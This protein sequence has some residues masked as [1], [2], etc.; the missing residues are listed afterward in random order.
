MLTIFTCART[1][2]MHTGLLLQRSTIQLKILIVR[3]ADMFVGPPNIKIRPGTYVLYNSCMYVSN[4][5]AMFFMTQSITHD[6]HIT[7][8][9]TEKI[10]TYLPRSTLIR[11]QACTYRGQIESPKTS[12]ID[13]SFNGLH[14][15]INAIFLCKWDFRVT[16]TAY[17]FKWK[18]G[19]NISKM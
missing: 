9:D 15:A 10:L 3:M 19:S 17:L 14:L 16:F 4:D 6:S 11:D 12:R 7:G 18:K 2:V 13:L 5:T 1:Y 8:Y